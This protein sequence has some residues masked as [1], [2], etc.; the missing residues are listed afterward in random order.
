MNTNVK[1]LMVLNMNAV[2]IKI[3]LELQKMGEIEPTNGEYSL[4]EPT[5]EDGELTPMEEQFIKIADGLN[6]S[7]YVFDG[8]EVSTV[9]LIAFK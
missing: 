5:F 7:V 2:E 6:Y 8:D 4:L 9:K 3:A 1:D